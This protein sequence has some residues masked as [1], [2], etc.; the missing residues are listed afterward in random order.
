MYIGNLPE[1]T[2]PSAAGYVPYSEDGYHLSKI[3]RDNLLKGAGHGTGMVY[4]D[5]GDGQI[6]ND[7]TH[8][9]IPRTVV[10]SLYSYEVEEDGKA[11]WTALYPSA[12]WSSDITNQ[13]RNVWELAYE[14]GGEVT[15]IAYMDNRGKIFISNYTSDN[16]KSTKYVYEDSEGNEV[17][18][19]D[20]FM[21]NF[22]A[23][24][25][26]SYDGNTFEGWGATEIIIN[27]IHYQPNSDGDFEI[28]FSGD[29]KFI[30]ESGWPA[31][32]LTVIGTQAPNGYYMNGE[33]YYVPHKSLFMCDRYGIAQPLSIEYATNTKNPA[34]FNPDQFYYY[35]SNNDSN[36]GEE[37]DNNYVYLNHKQVPINDMF[38][39]QLSNGDLYLVGTYGSDG[40]FYLDNNFLSQTLPSSQDDKI[41]IYLG[42]VYTSGSVKY[43]DFQLNKPKYWYLDNAVRPYSYIPTVSSPVTDVLIDGT[44]AIGD[45]GQLGLYGS[46]TIT[47]RANASQAGGPK[48]AQIQV[49]TS[50]LAANLLNNQMPI[51]YGNSTSIGRNIVG[52]VPSGFMFQT[53]SPCPVTMLSI[54][55]VISRQDSG[56]L[57]TGRKYTAW[58]ALS[59]D[60]NHDM[61]PWDNSEGGYFKDCAV[62]GANDTEIVLSLS[63]MW[64]TDNYTQSTPASINADIILDLEA[65]ESLFVDSVITATKINTPSS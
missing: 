65:G 44:S 30:K 33:Q 36:T 23:G 57:T 9:N 1:D 31:K 58:L 32:G 26:I 14:E 29:F 63:G 22:V 19:L 59:S 24:D 5:E 51:R 6:V 16:V 4:W 37:L 42:V 7:G 50:M 45:N 35:D 40:W 39:V 27:G 62:A 47:V 52:N 25:G 2:T 64:K 28:D 10:G 46:N 8:T 54:T 20:Y 18:L 60:S 61:V 13:V 21:K 12:Y 41:Y 3:S 53:S 34:A 38:G 56:V 48:Y 17:N 11:Y 15:Y 43:L 49:N 55:I